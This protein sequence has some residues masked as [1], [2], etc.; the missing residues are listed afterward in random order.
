MKVLGQSCRGPCC[1]P[2]RY[3]QY[4]DHTVDKDS[5]NCPTR[6]PEK[7]ET[8][9]EQLA[10]HPRRTLSVDA[11]GR[12]TTHGRD[13]WQDGPMSLSTDLRRLS[14]A[15]ARLACLLLIVLM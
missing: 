10:D 3:R 12:D 14:A 13:R 7:N 2:R 4:F 11:H 8:I 9:P 15:S 1:F 6:R 5:D